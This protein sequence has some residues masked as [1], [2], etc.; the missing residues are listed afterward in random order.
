MS[1]FRITE[2]G[3]CVGCEASESFRRAVSE[4]DGFIAPRMAT[5]YEAIARWTPIERDLHT[6][7]RYRT[8]AA[9]CGLQA[10]QEQ[11]TRMVDEAIRAFRPVGCVAHVVTLD[12][13][14][15]PSVRIILEELA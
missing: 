10:L 3:K 9:Y 2:C 7:A 4:I 5:V 12:G 13:T 14:T 15:T 1:D 11:R 6:E 8:N